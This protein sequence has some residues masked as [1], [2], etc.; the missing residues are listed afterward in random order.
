VEK[1]KT[2]LNMT[3][4]MSSILITMYRVTG[5]VRCGCWNCLNNLP[6]HTVQELTVESPWPAAT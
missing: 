5:P 4:V 1:F 3:F 6:L 2:M